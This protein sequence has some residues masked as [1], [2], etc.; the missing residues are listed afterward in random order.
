VSNKV[1]I[2]VNMLNDFI[3]PDGALSCGH[4]AMDIVPVVLEKIR[5]FISAGL[6]VIFIMDAHDPEDHEFKRLP[7]HCVYGTQGA[8]LIKEIEQE[9]EEY[10]FTI[11]VFKSRYSGFFRT[12]LN[13]II[14]ELDPGLVEVVGVCT[15]VCV[16][17]TVE[18]LRNRNYRVIVY[19]NG[20]ASSD[21][22]AH[23]WALEQMETVLGAEIV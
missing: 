8:R 14:R 17:Y 18:E 5:G 2:V 23:R 3:N 4:Q 11:K 16:L 15:N 22:E 19:K 7:V 9:V 20:V 10:S 13:T 1:L 6:P 12:N 21:P